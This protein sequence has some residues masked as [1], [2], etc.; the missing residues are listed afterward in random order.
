MRSSYYKVEKI[1]GKR[2]LNGK[3]QYLV[4]WKGYGDGQSTWEKEENLNNCSELI[5]KYE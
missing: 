1:T 3:I 2:I 5:Q 4:K